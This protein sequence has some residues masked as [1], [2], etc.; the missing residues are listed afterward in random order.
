MS[1]GVV[2]SCKQPNV[3]VLTIEDSP[4][5]LQ[6]APAFCG[7]YSPVPASLQ[8]SGH[9]ALNMG[10]KK[11]GHDLKTFGINWVKM[12]HDTTSTTVCEQNFIR[13]HMMD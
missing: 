9:P 5:Y 7:V 3:F 4:E 10:G 13:R 2:K 1:C 11:T 6:A 12:T 8:E